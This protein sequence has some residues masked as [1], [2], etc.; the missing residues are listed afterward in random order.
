[1]RQKKQPLVRFGPRPVDGTCDHIPHHSAVS[2]Y[3]RLSVSEMS[4]LF[5]FVCVFFF[6]PEWITLALA[7][8]SRPS[9][10]RGWSLPTLGR[11]QSLKDSIWLESWKWNWR[12]RFLCSTVIKVCSGI[13][14]CHNHPD[15]SI[16]CLPQG[17]LAERIRAGGAGVPAFF[18]ATG[19]GTLIQE[20]GSPIKYNKDGT[21]AIS[22]EKR[23]VRALL[24]TMLFV[25]ANLT[26]GKTKLVFPP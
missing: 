2:G 26:C 25:P 14:V 24:S 12:H 9:R 22:S 19:Y 1:M 17:T 11:M 10:S 8:F 16:L 20:G 7:C 23:E 3:C 15:L 6:F 13:T 18:T 21:I 4:T 5:S